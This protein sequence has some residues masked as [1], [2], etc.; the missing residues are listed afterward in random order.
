MRDRSDTTT[1]P[2]AD[3]CCDGDTFAPALSARGDLD[4]RRNSTLSSLRYQLFGGRRQE[5]R[6]ENDVQPLYVERYE[7]SLLYVSL[8]ILL[9]SCLDAFLTLNLL[10]SGAVEVNPFMAWLINTDIQ[11]FVNV[12][13]ALTGVCIVLLVPHKH[14][15]LFGLVSID[16]VLRTLLAMYAV[17]TAYEAVLLGC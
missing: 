8:S 1:L 13:V 14:Y 9:L 6:R 7:S 17:L 12:K 11:L 10:A 4:R 16:R 3:M 5:A 15:R 2:L